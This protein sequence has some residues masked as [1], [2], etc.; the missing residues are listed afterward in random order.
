M[1]PERA[2]SADLFGPDAQAL[3]GACAL[4]IASRVMDPP[5]DRWERAVSRSVRP[6]IFGMVRVVM[7]TWR[8]VCDTRVEYVLTRWRALPV[9]LSGLICLL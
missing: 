4:P 7:S 6:R 9:D 5:Q 1:S 8:Y 2:S 3:P